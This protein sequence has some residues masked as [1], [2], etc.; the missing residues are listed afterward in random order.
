MSEVINTDNYSIN[1]KLGFLINCYDA[2]DDDRAKIYINITCAFVDCTQHISPL[3]NQKE[4][5]ELQTM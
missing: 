4:L 5:V 3:S 1:K 2:I